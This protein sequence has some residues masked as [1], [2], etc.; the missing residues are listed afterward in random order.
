MPGWSSLSVDR[1]SSWYPSC[2]EYL[3][4]ITIRLQVRSSLKPQSPGSGGLPPVKIILGGVQRGWETL[5]QAGQSWVDSGCCC[6]PCSSP[7]SGEEGKASSRLFSWKAA[8]LLRSLWLVPE[9]YDQ[10]CGRT[11]W[12]NY[13]LCVSMRCFSSS[14]IKQAVFHCCGGY[15]GRFLLSAPHHVP[16]SGPVK[17][18]CKFF[19]VYCLSRIHVIAQAGWTGC[20]NVF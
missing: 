4:E 2:F 3:E 16:T 6:P 19:F 14:C 1:L 10:E 7:H 5:L 20:T 15:L 9:D 11:D 17:A 8:I 13:N 18:S 12:R